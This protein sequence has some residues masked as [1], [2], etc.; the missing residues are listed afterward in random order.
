MLA[1]GL[2]ALLAYTATA[3]QPATAQALLE[4][5]YRPYL[6][7][8]HDGPSAAQYPQ[9]LVPELVRA[10]DEDF[11][12]AERRK[13]VPTL[14][15]DAFLD[16]GG[17]DLITDLTVTVS[18]NGDK[19]TGAV[20]FVIQSP[21]HGVDRRQLTIDLVQTPGGWRIYDIASKRDFPNETLR[22]L[23]KLRR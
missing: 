6:R 5:V 1:A 11:K 23:F 2:G 3:Q 20:G 16:A 15:G 14:S 13:E 9:I 12:Q 8:G 17:P 19:A 10:I 22:G 4:S 7:K 21:A 18:V